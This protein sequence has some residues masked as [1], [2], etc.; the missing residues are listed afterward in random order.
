MFINSIKKDVLFL[1]MH[2]VL[3]NFVE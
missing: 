1:G 3:S 2:T